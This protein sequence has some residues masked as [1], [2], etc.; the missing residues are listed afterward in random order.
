MCKAGRH[1][2]EIQMDKH[3]AQCFYSGEDNENAV[4]LFVK[5]G[6]VG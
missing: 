1:F 3:A 5:L 6:Q 2:R 4:D